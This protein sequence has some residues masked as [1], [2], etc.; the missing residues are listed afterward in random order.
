MNIIN[1]L[2]FIQIAIAFDFGLV[3]ISGDHVMSVINKQVRNEL[4]NKYAGT[5]REAEAVQ[6]KYENIHNHRVNVSRARLKNELNSLLVSINP[7]SAGWGKYAHLGASAGLFGLLTL[8]VIALTSGNHDGLLHDF[9]LISAEFTLC[10]QLITLIQ[11][12]KIKGGKISYIKGLVKVFQY[13][14]LILIAFLLAAV[15][16]NVEF[17]T[18][19]NRTFVIASIII[20]YLPL[21]VYMVNICIAIRQ[22]G[23]IN[24][25]C[26]N[27]I[28]D[29]FGKAS[30]YASK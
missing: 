10:Y 16:L 27:A 21:L 3:Y 20:V 13:L 4:Y 19:F 2:P 14:I 24:D 15:G 1:I 11:M 26:K 5:I 12:Y 17:W 25:K 7:D 28:S 6:K 22:I 23:K 18:N 30:A 9:L 29:F 8:F